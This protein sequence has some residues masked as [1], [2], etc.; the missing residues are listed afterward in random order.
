[1]LEFASYYLARELS[2]KVVGQLEAL[3]KLS[4][5]ICENLEAYLEG[6]SRKKNNCLIVGPTGNGKTEIARALSQKLKVPFTKVSITEYT[7]TGYKGKDPHEIVTAEFASAVKNSY[8]GIKDLAK[9]YYLYKQALAAFC[10]SESSPEKLK[11]ALEYAAARVFLRHTRVLEFM[12]DRFNGSEDALETASLI[13][14]IAGEILSFPGFEEK[15]D[16]DFPVLMSFQKRPFGLIFIDEADKLLIKERGDD[17]EG[18]YRS[19]QYHLLELIEGGWVRA[20]K[21][22]DSIDTSHIT[23]ILAGA[24][25]ETSPEEFAPELKGR[26]NVRINVRKLGYEDYLAIISSKMQEYLP[27]GDSTNSIPDVVVVENDAKIELAKICEKENEKE[28]L[29][30]RRLESLLSKIRE[31]VE[32]D[33][34]HGSVLPVVVN[35]SFVR[36]ALEADFNFQIPML[37]ELSQEKK[38]KIKEIRRKSRVSKDNMV[39]ARVLFLR[40]ELKKIRSGNPANFILQDKLID[41]LLLTDSTGK[42][43]LEYLVED[44]TISSLSLNRRNLK[45]L[46]NALGKEILGKIKIKILE[47]PEKNSKESSADEYDLDINLSEEEWEKFFKWIEDSDSENS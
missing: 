35:A 25:T 24:F 9:N 8:H 28:Y 29:G 1:M 40:K 36:W 16:K 42:S 13:E 5:A 14:E 41:Y 23:F 46:K 33:L 31:A 20:E 12:Y 11:A 37:P 4:N 2:E 45:L 44:G 32:W 38:E 34:M 6:R 17:E 7:L 22:S 18:F 15:K 47:E 21:S 43:V 30:V 27:S 3:F 19:L 10:E 39:K 26:L